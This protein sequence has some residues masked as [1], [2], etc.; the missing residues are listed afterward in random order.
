MCCPRARPAR[1]TDLLDLVNG[2]REELGIVDLD[3]GPYT[4]MRLIIGDQPDGGINV[5]S[6][7]HPFANYVITEP[8]LEYHALKVPSGPQTGIKIVHGFEISADQ[9]TELTLDFDAARSVVKAGSSGNWLLKPTVKV[10][11][12]PEYAIVRGKVTTEGDPEANRTAIPGALVSAQQQDAEGNPVV[13]A[14]TVTGADGS[15]AL[16]I[17]PDPDDVQIQFDNRYDIVASLKGYEANCVEVIT[18][19]R[20]NQDPGTTSVTLAGPMATGTMTG[21]VTISGGGQDQ[22][23]TLS[24]RQEREC[25]SADSPPSDLPGI[26]RGESRKFC[27]L[28]YLYD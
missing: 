17:K 24:F 16:F 4:Q 18:T 7:S 12:L 9:T 3:D 23:V 21:A 15:Y 13:F 25:K 27:E 19:P 26:R 2:V 10:L 8:D 20:M 11:D 28:R 22:Y 5:L 1:P 14:S 6:R